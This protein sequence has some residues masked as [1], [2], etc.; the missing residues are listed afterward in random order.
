MRG[1]IIPP[2]VT[3]AGGDH[4]VPEKSIKGQRLIETLTWLGQD[5][6][7]QVF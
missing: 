6:L 3:V 1:K 7:N 4:I 5:T 2:E